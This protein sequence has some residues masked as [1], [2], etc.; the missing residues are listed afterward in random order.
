MKSKSIIIIGKVKSD[1]SIWLE[2][3]SSITNNIYV[4]RIRNE[5]DKQR[6]NSLIQ[7]YGTKGAYNTFSMLTHI[8]MQDCISTTIDNHKLIDRM[9][10]NECD[11]YLKIELYTNHF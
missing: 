8:M 1:N 2:L 9:R 6:L 5:K 11:T 10:K 3:Q 7:H 4:A